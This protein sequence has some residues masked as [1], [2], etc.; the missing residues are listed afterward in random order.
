MYYSDI[1][2]RHHSHSV[3]GS[4]FFFFFSVVALSICTASC[5]MFCCG[6]E[7]SCDA[8]TWY[9]RHAVPLVVAYRLSCSSACGI[10]GP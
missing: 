5:G 9:F 10:L 4:V 6:A 3:N 2:L 8:R 7:T 1:A